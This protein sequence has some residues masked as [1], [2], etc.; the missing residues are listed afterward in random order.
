MK[1]TMD[2]VTDRSGAPAPDT[3]RAGS[4]VPGWLRTYG[5]GAARA[6]AIAGLTLAA[7]LLPASIGDASLANLPPEAGLYAC[8][9]SGLV[10]WMLCSSRHTAVTVTSAISLLMG[11]TLGSLADGDA[12]RFGG[13]A[14]G[15]ALLV[16]ALAFGAWLIRAGSLVSFVSETVLIGFKAGVALT[17]ASTQLPKLFGIG[18]VHG[19]FW[20][21]SRHFIARLG[22]TNL[23][24]LVVGA[25]ALA[26]LVAG[27]FLLR[28]KPVAIFVVIGGI[29][30]A[31]AAN[32][33]ERGVKMLGE[34]PQGLPMPGLPDVRWDDLN[35]LLPLA[36]AC[37]LLGAVETS[38]IGR[39]FAAKHRGRLDANREFLALAG[40]NL[41]AGLGRGFPVSGGMSQ[42]L[43][44]ESAGARTPASGLA[45]ALVVLLV[46][47]F[48]SGLLRDLPQP[49][50]AAIVLMAVM[51][52][53]NVRALLHLWRTDRTE[54]L[55]AAA[56]LGGV[57]AS[58]LLRG[59]L[60][61]AVISLVLLIR[62]ASRPNVAFLGRIPGARRYSDM[63][64]HPDNQRVPGMVIFRSEGSL[65]YF[66][67]EHVRDRVMAEVRATAPR[68][69]VC[70]LS[71]SPHLDLGGAEMLSG[72]AAELEAM[73]IRLLIVEARSRV[74]D[75]L[76]AE[77]LEDRIG[78][79][80]RFT[81]VADAVD[82]MQGDIKAPE[83]AGS[84]AL[85]GEQEEKP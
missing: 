19:G 83:D 63:E 10:F 40:A 50:L 58:G 1:R 72:L 44:N 28:N 30:V 26:V 82:A 35:E 18:G 70:D 79:I 14:A 23:A 31:G 59:V 71:A 46:V 81:S 69:V 5:P 21:C 65:V 24:S 43:V 61:G 20:E 2:T 3:T 15:T 57:L 34:V 66:N 29:V 47:L 68:T 80:D 13:L 38:A 37:F 56:A 42:S 12:S 51:G 39:M 76:R 74:R 41:A 25:G 9:F 73:G 4:L 32:L 22:E 6:D 64:R 78:R 11:T 7:Y 48:L 27:K 16:A 36:M 67:A 49:V 53:V 75:R 33:D 84:N 60:I 45:A 52:L 17:L 55:I 8:M 54:L 62:R 85:P 77:G